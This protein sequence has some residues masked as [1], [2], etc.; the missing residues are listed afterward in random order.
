VVIFLGDLVEGVHHDQNEIFATTP[1]EQERVAITCIDEGLKLGGWKKGDRTYFVK[2]TSPTHSGK[3]G[4][5]EKRIA[6]DLSDYGVVYRIPGTPANEYMDGTP[7]FDH[8]RRT[9][10][11]HLIDAAHHTGGGS[12]RKWTEGNSLRMQ[13]RSIYY[14]CLDRQVQP[15]RIW[16][17][18]HIH[19]YVPVQEDFTHHTINAFTLPSWQL[20][21]EYAHK[22]ANNQKAADIGMMILE[23][24]KRNVKLH[25]RILDY[26]PEPPEEL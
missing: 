22:V 7:V 13:I 26:D 8:L 19:R 10:H 5:S 21:T 23:V 16:A 6:S 12:K 24:D 17:R 1:E 20:K 2:G 11:G 15:P 18:A 25:K 3:G 4:G 14:D 9:V